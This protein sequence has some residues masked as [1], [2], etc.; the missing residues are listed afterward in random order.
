MEFKHYF[1]A[2]FVWLLFNRSLIFAEIQ[3]KWKNFLI[4]WEI[5]VKV[6]F[7]IRYATT[8]C[9]ACWCV[10]VNLIPS[11]MLENWQNA[12][13]NLMLIYV[14]IF[15]LESILALLKKIKQV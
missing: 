3:K 6:L 9:A 13:T 11:L 15:S 14:F 4:R 7:V 2:Y 5:K 12:L 8:V 10:W 1:A